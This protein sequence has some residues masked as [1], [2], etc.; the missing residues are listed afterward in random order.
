MKGCLLVINSVLLL[1]SLFPDAA[2][3]YNQTVANGS[4]TAPVN[5]P[6][7]GCTYKW[8]NNTPGIGLPASGVGN[9][10]SFTA[11]NTTSS[12][13][14]ATITATP[15]PTGYAYI[16]NNSPGSVSV[17]D[18]T[19]NTV[20][21]NIALS[22][23]ALGVSASP[24]G[25]F[26]YVATGPDIV[27]V[28]NTATN[29]VAST[30]VVGSSPYGIAVSPDGG[31]VYVANS[32]SNS[33]SVINTGSNSVVATVPVGSFPWGIAVSPDGSLVYVVNDYSNNVSVINT[34][35]NTVTTTITVGTNPGFVAVSPD[36]SRVYVTNSG[37]NT[38]S[39]IN[40][41]TDKIVTNIIVGLGLTGIAISPDGN[42]VYVSTQTDNTAT[43]A[44]SVI[45]AA[46]NTVVATIHVGNQVWG[47]S[48]SPDGDR[49]YAV[50][51]GNITNLDGVVTNTASVW[52]INTA[53]DTVISTIAGF[54]API[55][56]GNFISPGPGCS[57]SPVTFTITVDPVLRAINAGIVTGSISACS[58]AASVSPNIQQFTVS[59]SNLSAGITATAP[60]G[61][62]VSLAPGSGYGT[63]VT[64]ALSG[65]SV[66]STEVYVRS[67][68]SASSGS[69]VGDVVIASA[70]AVS[71]EV[72]VTGTVNAQAAPSVTI[73]A[74][75]N[76]ICAGT[77]VTFKAT[78][79]NGGLAP[80]YQWVVNGNDSGTNSASFSSDA[81][82]NGDSVYCLMTG[83]LTCS[84][85]V[86]SAVVYL[87]IY[88]LPVVTFNPDTVFT[89]GNNGV[90]LSPAITG[91]IEKYQWSPAEGLSITNVDEP[92]ASPGG[93][94]T[95]QLQVTTDNGCTATGKVTVIHERSLEM[96]NSFTPNG[97][98]HDEV[99]RIPPGSQFY[100]EYFQIFDRWGGRVFST[101]DIGIGWDGTY[102]GVAANA[103][104]FVYM[105][106]GKT[107]AGEPVFLKGIVILIR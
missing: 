92:V 50:C 71:Q 17:V 47:I 58:G 93:I 73:I 105:I 70:G 14:T 85:P 107:L 30:I 8:T 34:A 88:P 72:A 68:A 46:T 52:V 15:V 7:V 101:Q 62:E 25:K 48:V 57:S 21:A 29:T 42:W 10:G 94:S 4:P 90:Q 5:F 96:P 3:Q 16:A 103:G 79:A 13:V 36:G 66:G 59:G 65:D 80:S 22:S 23:G 97:D 38:V 67:A 11:V 12:P 53:A 9:M 77:P 35:T 31:H 95:Y 98:G 89:A 44:V 27:S 60:P 2:A 18:T 63:S 6:A 102:N 45:N 1:F 39:V 51:A 74:S 33:V 37:A 86:P 84:G 75:A 69:M 26:V 83:N 40:T 87:V 19:T 91:T 61:F 104:V 81:L 100:L 78:P 28:L 76:N 99:F 82:N 55:S 49:V 41:A 32:A 20:V 43:D 56:I 54:S 24:N 64:V 106:K